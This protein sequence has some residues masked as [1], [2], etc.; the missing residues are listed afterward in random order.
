M[1]LN[2]YGV[3]LAGLLVAQGT[4]CEAKQALSHDIQAMENRRT[5]RMRIAVAGVEKSLDDLNSS[6]TNLYNNVILVAYSRKKAVHAATNTMSEHND[7]IKQTYKNLEILLENP[8][9]KELVSALTTFIDSLIKIINELPFYSREFNE[10]GDLQRFYREKIRKKL[11]PKLRELRAAVKNTQSAIMPKL[12]TIHDKIAAISLYMETT[13]IKE[14]DRQINP[15]T[16]RVPL[17]SFL[18]GSYYFSNPPR[19]IEK[20]QEVEDDSWFYNDDDDDDSWDYRSDTNNDTSCYRSDDGLCP[21]ETEKYCCTRG[22]DG[23]LICTPCTND[24]CDQGEETF[25]CRRK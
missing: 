2:R 7:A 3:M 11:Q 23:E 8:V 16:L 4:L 20:I 1:Q 5:M 9:I 12:Q 15:R 10:R 25:C 21:S 17:F 6:S 19:I 13:L 18:F 24:S 22:D 14:L